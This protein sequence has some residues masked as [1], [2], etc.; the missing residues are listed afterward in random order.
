MVTG[1]IGIED[2]SRLRDCFPDLVV[3]FKQHYTFDLTRA[4]AAQSRAIAATTLHGL[5]DVAVHVC[6][7][8]RNW[9]TIWTLEPYGCAAVTF[10]VAAVFLLSVR[11]PSGGAGLVMFRAVYR[12]EVVGMTL[13]YVQ[14]EVAHYPL[15]AS[16]NLG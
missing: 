5:R 2:P 9:A 10:W 7:Q 14:D 13:W 6:E 12:N 15:A 4:L 1:P 8:A 3:R 16:S 11:A